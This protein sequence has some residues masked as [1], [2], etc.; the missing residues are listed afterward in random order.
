MTPGPA[1][2]GVLIPEYPGQTHSFFWREMQSVRARS[3]HSVMVFSTRRPAKPVP[4]SWV[5]E[6]PATY[7]FPPPKAGFAGLLAAL[8]GALA[9]LMV[10][11]ATRPILRNPRNWLMLL[12]AMRLVRLCRTHDIRHLHVH[13]C[14]SAALVA[15][16]AR[17]IGGPPYSLVLHGA[18]QTYGP[19]QRF[20]WQG[21]RFVFVVS[22]M[23]RHQVSEI[24]PDMME[25]TSVVPM[26]VDVEIFTPPPA[27]REPGEGFT[28]FCCAR[29]NRGKGHDTLL[30]ALHRLRGEGGDVRLVIAGEDEQGGSG[31]R[32]EIEKEIDRLGLRDVV[33]LLGAVRQEDV[34][35]H[36]QSSDGFVLAS[37]N[38]ALG[39]AYM[40]A[41]ACGLPVI[42]TAVGGVGEVIDDG[43]NGL[44][45][46]PGDAGALAAAMKRIMTDRPFAD[47]LGGNAREKIVTR[48]S[49]S[50]S[51]VE[52]LA[53]I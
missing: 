37:R 2:L 42:G 3:G 18:I 50:R 33:T 8:P 38:E 4:H 47:R 10:R 35:R 27:R 31:Y 53:R 21:A 19:H 36:L 46:P 17:Q 22:E 26:G 52:L 39:V 44:L 43:T 24:L 12:M 11:P 14:A 29:L 6:A 45:V 41:M 13:S 32:R 15:A 7:L 9:R 20:K 51:A 23:L 25:K 49:A 1:R 34:V 40:E 48:F 30:E 16:L 5:S 28:W